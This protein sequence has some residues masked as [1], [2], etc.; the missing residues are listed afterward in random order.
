MLV[1]LGFGIGV[2]GLLYHLREVTRGIDAWIEGLL[3]ERRLQVGT[4]LCDL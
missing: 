3:V 2:A 1:A 4:R